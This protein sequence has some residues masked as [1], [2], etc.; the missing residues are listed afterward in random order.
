MR[1]LHFAQD[2]HKV[3]ARYRQQAADEAN[4]KPSGP[5][6]LQ[7]YQPPATVAPQRSGVARSSHAGARGD[8]GRT[9]RIPVERA[10]NM[11]RVTVRINNAVNAPFYIDTGAS[12]VAIP[13]WV[14][15]RAGIDLEG[16]RTG[17]Y[18]TANGT[19]E[20]PLVTLDS[21]D[22]AGARVEGVPASVSDS[23]QVGLLG[24]SFF[25]HFQYHVDPARGVVTLVEND[26]ADEGK[27][28][29]GRSEPQWRSEFVQ[30]HY[31]IEEAQREKDSTPSSHGREH[32][33]LEELIAELE[34]QLEV[35]DGE[36][37]DAHVPFGWRD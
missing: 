17:R 37:D 13:R 26:L 15:E 1:W 3:P 11:L 27:I 16:A 24:L 14:V 30:L 32:S 19:I 35:L 12:D 33:R 6:P 10:G 8:K 2:L 31:R 29:G 20:V 25:N 9:Y 36:A 7:T 18:G 23:M 21:V 5:D 4:S 34:R 22:L 28:R